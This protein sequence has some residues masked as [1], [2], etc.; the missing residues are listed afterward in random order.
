MCCIRVRGEGPERPCLGLSMEMLGID[1]HEA[2]LGLLHAL[3]LLPLISGSK[4]QRH[5][6]LT[7]LFLACSRRLPAVDNRQS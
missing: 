2:H 3:Q 4:V 5:L 6:Q 7:M 1:T